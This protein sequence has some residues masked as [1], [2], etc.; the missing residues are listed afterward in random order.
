MYQLSLKPYY[1]SLSRCYKQIIVISPDPKG[2]LLSISKRVNPAPL[3]TF[4]SYSDCDRHQSCYYALLNPQNKC[5][6]LNI[7]DLPIL[8][9]F[10][11]ENDFK[12]QN[13]LTKILQNANTPIG[14]TL[15]FYIN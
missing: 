2:I 1:D 8:L 15:L 12:I 6:F 14:E 10:L 7:H 9:D 5:E 11:T 13:K 4:R 3:T